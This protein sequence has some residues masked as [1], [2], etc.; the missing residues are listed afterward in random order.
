MRGLLLVDLQRDYFPDGAYP[1]VGA[2]LAVARAGEVLAAFRERGEPVVHVQHHWDA[3]E[4][5]FLRPGTPGA[6]LHEA[7]AP[8]PPEPVVTKAEPNSFVGT[9]LEELLRQNGIDDLVVAGMMTS[10]CVDSTVRAAV[11]LGHEVT[12]VHDAC[13]APDLDFAGD[14]VDGATV[15]RAFVAALSGGYATVVAAADLH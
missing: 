10:M 13:A 11:D 3:P 15:H 14:Q 12:L 5:T 9:G 4:A 1:L 2:D 6:E 7:V 8:V